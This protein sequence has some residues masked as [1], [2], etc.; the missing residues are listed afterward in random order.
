MENK[1][2]QMTTGIKDMSLILNKPYIAYVFKKTQKI[3]QALYLLT[4][5]FEPSEPLRS[6]IRINANLLLNNASTLLKNDQKDKQNSSHL[7]MA[8]FLET[9]AFIEI[10][11][12]INLLSDK[13]YSI[14]KGEINSMIETLE[15][16]K[17][18]AIQLSME[19]IE[20]KSLEDHKRQS[21]LY[22]GHTT[23]LNVK[24]SPLTDKVDKMP[25]LIQLENKSK[26]LDTILAFFKPG[27]ELM[28][29]DITSHFKDVSEKTVQR[30]LLLLVS[31]K[32]LNKIGKK[33][34]S[35][36]S[37]N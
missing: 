26:R 8:T 9:L 27:K 33:R 11:S 22:K 23:V 10:A 4:D 14:L 17:E 25:K 16:H 15:S 6:S 29:K 21:V 32:K 30:E 34:W 2:T 1:E 28:I 5:Y 37:L 18:K 3:T 35:K 7:L 31:Q 36:Y 13:N 20:T 19:F 24:D 12:L